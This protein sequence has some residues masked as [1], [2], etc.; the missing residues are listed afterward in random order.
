MRC[1]IHYRIMQASLD[2]YVMNS[3][4]RHITYLW[5]PHVGS[6][7]VLSDVKVEHFILHSHGLALGQIYYR[8]WNNVV[9]LLL[10]DRCSYDIP[11]EI[12]IG[13]RTVVVSSISLQQVSQLVSELNHALGRYGDLWPLATSRVSLGDTKEAASLVLLQIQV[14]SPV[15][16]NYLR[17]FKLAIFRYFIRV[18]RTCK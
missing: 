8:L 7:V 4:T 18:G 16:T 13:P 3:S 15:V 2:R 1:S 6:A 10:T 14:V 12:E 11:T 9:Q 5:D 17:T